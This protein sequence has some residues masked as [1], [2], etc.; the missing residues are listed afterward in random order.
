M[1]K[2]ADDFRCRA[3][4][5]CWRILVILRQ[6]PS[7]LQMLAEDLGVTTRT[8][9]RDLKALQRVPLPIG[10]RSR[11]GLRGGDPNVWILGEVP[12]WP[13]REDLPTRPLEA[14]S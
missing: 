1:A 9:R 4:V 8:I 10:I 2:W 6:R 5:R 11:R 13:R 12:E 7:T 3:L 14:R